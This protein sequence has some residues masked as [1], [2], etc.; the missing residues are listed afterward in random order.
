M[1]PEKIRRGLVCWA[2]RTTAVSA[3]PKSIRELKPNSVNRIR[4]GGLLRR[5]EE[6][7]HPC[8]VS[9]KARAMRRYSERRVSAQQGSV[10]PLDQE[11]LPVRLLSPRFKGWN[12]W[13]PKP[14]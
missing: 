4:D 7:P 3:Q 8:G 12:S 6:P 14:K 13:I 9:D 1:V 5:S 10:L 11:A 2:K